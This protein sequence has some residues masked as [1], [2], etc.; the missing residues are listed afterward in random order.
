MNLVS[1]KLLTIVVE[2]TIANRL[3]DD[4]IALGA[5]GFTSGLATGTGPKDSAANYI[6]GGNLRI[7]TVVK[8]DVLERILEK[9]EAS[10]FPNYSVTAWV[11]DVGVIRQDRY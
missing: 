6:D 8:D 4:L 11:T 10:Y 3:T 1:R 7:E 5:K 2:T 9:L